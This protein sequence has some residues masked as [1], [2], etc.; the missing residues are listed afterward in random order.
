MKIL[1]LTADHWPAVQ[2]IYAQG[3]AT[4]SATFAT[5]VPP[6][7]EWDARHLPHSRLVAVAEDGTVLGWAALT[8]VSGRCVYAGVAE[9]SVYVDQAARGQGVGRQLLAALVAASEQHGI[10][11][12]QAGIFDDNHGSLRLHAS[13]GFRTVGYRER[14]GRLHGVWRNTLLLERRSTVVGVEAERPSATI[15]RSATDSGLATA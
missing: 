15:S 1:P 9:V 2:A 12:L 6:L 8:P 5:D 13:A 14:I 10:W 7:A 4:G 3:I 11:T